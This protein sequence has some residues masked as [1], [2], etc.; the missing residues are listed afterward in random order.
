[1]ILSQGADMGQDRA[2]VQPQGYAVVALL[3][4]GALDRKERAEDRL[5]AIEVEIVGPGEALPDLLAQF[6]P[7]RGRRARAQPAQDSRVRGGLA[8]SFGGPRGRNGQPGQQLP[9]QFLDYAIRVFGLGAGQPVGETV[10][11]GWVYPALAL[12]QAQHGAV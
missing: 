3:A 7:A 6:G 2:A 11:R 4:R 1:M 9:E 12:Q 5:L 10:Q 8:A